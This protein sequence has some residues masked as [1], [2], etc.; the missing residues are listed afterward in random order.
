MRISNDANTEIEVIDGI[1]KATSL[2]LANTQDNASAAENA[3]VLIGE[4][5]EMARQGTVQIERMVKAVDAIQQSYTSITKVVESIDAIAFQ[6]NILALNAAVEAARAGQYGRGFAV[7]ADEVR[8]L[9]TKSSES[10]RSTDELIAD[11]LRQVSTGVEVTNTAAKT[12]EEIV[13]K[14]D[15]SDEMIERISAASAEQIESLA[16]INEDIERMSNMVKR[17]ATS[18]ESSALVSDTL[19]GRAK[20]LTGILEKYKIE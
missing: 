17:L 20:Q 12:F 5:A 4:M 2:I 11:A 19:S 14:I 1:S 13:Q 6:T 7:V 9:A 8:S 10:A 15:Q 18:A 16:R 3:D